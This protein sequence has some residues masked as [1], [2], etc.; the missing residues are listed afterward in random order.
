VIVLDENVDEGEWALLRRWRMPVCQVGRDV[1]R[2]GMQDADILPLLRTLRRPTFV[3]SDHYFFDMALCSD[4]YCLVYI[5]VRAKE[6]ATHTRRL[7]RHSAFKTWAQR[8]GCV[9]RVSPTGIAVWRPHDRKATRYR[10]D[11]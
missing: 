9:V 7:L 11:G 5:D 2:S 8:Q 1:G 4:R 6:V 3:S 10:W